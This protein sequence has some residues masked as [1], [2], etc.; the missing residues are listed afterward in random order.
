MP[1]GNNWDE[2]FKWTDVMGSEG[3]WTVLLR[4]V[5][6]NG[7]KVVFLPHNPTLPTFSS[8]LTAISLPLLMV[9]SPDQVLKNQPALIDVSSPFI[10]APPSAISQFYASIGGS[11]RLP[12]PYTQ[13]FA[14]PCL[15]NQYIA[16]EIGGW[17]FPVMSG[18]GSSE[19]ALYGAAGGL[20]SLGKLRGMGEGGKEE[21]NTGYCVGR[22]VESR[23]GEGREG[24]E[25]GMTDLW[26]LGEPFFRGL[27]V[28]FD[29][30]TKRVGAR[31][32]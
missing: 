31:S 21:Y 25:A 11:N 22:V 13:F 3:W 18:E 16:F 23:V 6:V 29:G 19:D 1:E 14:I 26:V 32:Y 5:W 7:A 24:M 2:H 9:L 8:T 12:P 20:F 17:N 30:E 28:V 27:G 10:L 4:G 15:N